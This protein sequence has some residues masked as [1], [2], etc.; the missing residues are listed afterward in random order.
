MDAPLKLRRF[1]N[2]ED[3]QNVVENARTIS[4]PIYVEDDYISPEMAESN[5]RLC[6][7][8]VNTLVDERTAL[9]DKR[10]AFVDERTAFVDERIAPVSVRTT[11]VANLAHML[12]TGRPQVGTLRKLLDLLANGDPVGLFSQLVTREEALALIERLAPGSS[13]AWEIKRSD[14]TDVSD[15]MEGEAEEE[16][17]I[18]IKMDMLG[19]MSDISSN[20]VV[21]DY[22]EVAVCGRTE[23][24]PQP[25]DVKA[26]LGQGFT[27]TRATGEQED[28]RLSQPSGRR[29]PP[30]SLSKVG[31]RQPSA[32]TGTDTLYRE[33]RSAFQ[34]G[35]GRTFSGE[36]WGGDVPS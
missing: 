22:P 18:D 17:V 4:T 31:S 35:R 36:G 12:K 25:I 3:V 26:E 28:E 5:S 16:G 19:H 9:T 27:L 13:A 8:E 15:G 21:A 11:L 34:T 20:E 10:T 30:F 32:S 23:R 14:L 1:N 24:L 2:F 7:P 29:P 6:V 33:V